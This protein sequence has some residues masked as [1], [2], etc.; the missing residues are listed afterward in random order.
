MSLSG[1]LKIF[2]FS[3]AEASNGPRE[4]QQ[5]EYGPDRYDMKWHFLLRDFIEYE[6]AHKKGEVVFEGPEWNGRVYWREDLGYLLHIVSDKSISSED[7]AC[8][9]ESHKSPEAERVISAIAGYDF[10]ATS[11]VVL[12][13]NVVSPP[14]SAVRPRL[15][16]TVSLDKSL[17]NH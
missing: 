17:I 8:E 7:T 11:S 2:G 1:T 12:S 4:S 15:W 10:D 6:E 14:A 13:N 16:L 3:A 5:L 9:D